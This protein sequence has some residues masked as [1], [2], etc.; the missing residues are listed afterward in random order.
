MQ[1]RA[2]ASAL[3][4]LLL[5]GALAGWPGRASAESDAGARV[6]AAVATFLYVPLRVLFAGSGLLFGGVGWG[7]SGGDAQVAAAIALPAV[8]GDYLVTPA[9]LR[10]ERRLEFVGAAAGAG[11]ADPVELAVD[12]WEL[13]ETDDPYAG[14]G[15]DAGAAPT[16]EASRRWS[17]EW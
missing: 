13:E 4:A 3:V 7:L 1:A 8:R 12:D 16:S 5:A 14:G 17:A 10:G 11:A 6:G 2:T 9:H 15:E